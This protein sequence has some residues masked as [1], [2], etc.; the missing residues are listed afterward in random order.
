M[1]QFYVQINTLPYVSQFVGKQLGRLNFLPKLTLNEISAQVG[2]TSD[3]QQ[4][5][6]AAPIAPT[7]TRMSKRLPD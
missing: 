6:P 5:I 4:M 3:R 1:G 2:I 7:S